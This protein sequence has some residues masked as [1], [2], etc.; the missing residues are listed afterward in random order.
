MN[1]LVAPIFRGFRPLQFMPL[2]QP[3][4]IYTSMR[5]MLTR[6]KENNSSNTSNISSFA[7]N[8]IFF[9]WKQ[10]GI[11]LSARL[12]CQT[13]I[14]WSITYKVQSFS[15]RHKLHSMHR[16][17]STKMTKC[18]L[19]KKWHF[20]KLAQKW[21]PMPPLDS[22]GFLPPKSYITLTYSHAQ[23]Y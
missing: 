4:K 6:G 13:K 15:C 17:N 14:P 11:H 23:K 22:L 1:K 12:S 9:T 7:N 21:N 3:P 16:N 8:I 18:H 2:V 20:Y 5:T 10:K 19:I